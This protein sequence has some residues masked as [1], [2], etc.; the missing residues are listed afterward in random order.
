MKDVLEDIAARLRANE[1]ANEEHI[2]LSLV[3]R[4]LQ[5]LGWNIWNPQ[6][7]NTEFCA[8]R[9]EDSTR[10]DVALFVR[11]TD[12]SVYIEVKA[13]GK[14]DK[15]LA[16]IERQMRDYN[17]NNTAE[18]SVLTDGRKWRFYLSQTGG[19]FSQKFFKEVDLL[20]GVETP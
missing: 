11:R 18:F 16:D 13:L 14:I 3:A 1:Y 20:D 7:V 15:N 2:R 17:R 6:E 19:E 12:P 8:T 10:V 5:A 9:N 4:L